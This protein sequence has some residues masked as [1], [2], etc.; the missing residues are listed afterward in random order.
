MDI[1]PNHIMVN[2]YVNLF[3]NGSVDKTSNIRKILKMYFTISANKSLINVYLINTVKN[4]QLN[5]LL[6]KNKINKFLFS[7]Y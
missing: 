7:I 6:I 3:T 1:K 5:S 4:Q 2:F